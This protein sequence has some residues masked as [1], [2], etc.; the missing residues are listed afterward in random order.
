MRYS[1]FN[2]DFS[3]VS[4]S[5]LTELLEIREGWYV[6][7]KS[8]LPKPKDIAKILSSFANQY[9]GWLFIG[10]NEDPE[11]LTAQNIPGI[12]ADQVTRVLE[13]VR[14]AAK[15][16]VRPQVIFQTRILEGPL[17]SVGLPA[18]Q[19]VIVIHIPEGSNTPYIHNDGRIYIRIGDSSSP[20]AATDKSTFDTLYQRGQDRQSFLKS[21]VQRI[22]QISKGEED[23]PFLHLN[24]L[25]DPYDTLGHWYEGAYSDFCTTMRGATI[26]FDNIFTSP[27]GFVARQIGTNNSYNRTL[28]WEFSRNCNSFVTI[29]LQRLPSAGSGNFIATDVMEEWKRH[30]IGPDFLNAL[31]SRGLGD[32]SVLNLNILLGAI[33]AIV[34]RHRRIVGASGIKGPFFIKAH[35][36]NVWRAIPFVDLN[37]YSDHV[38]DFGFPVIQDNQYM[39]P[40]RFSLDTFVVSPEMAHVPDEHEKIR[41]NGP[42]EIWLEIMQALGIPGELIAKHSEAFLEA[43]I[44][45]S[46]MQRARS[47]I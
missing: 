23:Q 29:P 30:E 12:A 37:S 38:K 1:P 9:G 20:V 6:E 17:E 47:G 36:E 46:G 21:L 25:S 45:E 15:D 16:I 26:P 13:T 41:F 44:R 27:N 11:S 3:E 31:F 40:P 14:N 5:D 4:P 39:I 19:S 42:I 24:I 32:C 8:Q 7:Y 33:G 10:V 34:S 35:I 22:P 18:Q 2:K 43:S 28:T